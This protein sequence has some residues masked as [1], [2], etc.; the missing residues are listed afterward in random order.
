[1]PIPDHAVV[2]LDVGHGNSAVVHTSDKVI[3]IDA[4]PKR[5]LIE[6]L[7][8]QSVRTIDTVLISHADE[9]HIGGLIGIVACR[10][11]EIGC[12]RLNTDSQKDTKSWDDLI[13]ALDSE[14]IPF[15]PA[16]AQGESFEY[17]P[18]QLSILGPSSFL[19]AKGPGG[20]DYK[21]RRVRTNSISAVI[22]VEFEENPVVLFPG[23]LDEIGLDEI[24]RKEVDIDAPVLVFPH[25]GGNPGTQDLVGFARQICDKVSPTTVIFSQKR[26]GN[27]LPEI[28][29]ILRAHNADIR[30]SCTQLS[31][32]C[33]S[34]V[35]SIDPT[36][37][38]P[39]Y[40]HGRIKGECCG[41]SFIIDLSTSTVTPARELHREFISGNVPN[42]LCINP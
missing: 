39:I 16:L 10:K 8:E 37:L 11:F 9:D 2:I 22:R 20:T 24:R 12:V 18:V 25:H 41:G 7:E 15:L 4:G 35:P 21:G 30:V 14:G 32:N 26:S 3:V 1:M 38:L 29:K 33:S 19:A 13:K 34:E 27:P 17:G 23:D 40:S 6:Y 31:V 5:P 36:H 28:V 42:N